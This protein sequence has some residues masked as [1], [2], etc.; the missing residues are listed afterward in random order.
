MDET[1]AHEVFLGL[2]TNLGD[3][4]ENLLSAL[5]LLGGMKG[6]EI[7]EVSS[8]YETEPWGVLD[9]PGFLNMVAVAHTSRDPRGVLDACREVEEEMGRIRD[10]KWGPRIIDVDILLYN[11]IQ[12]EQE[13][14]VIPH[15][16]MLEREFVLVP[17]LE[18]RPEISLPG[19]GRL[20]SCR[21]SHEDDKAIKAF[22]FGKE[23]WHG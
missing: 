19:A 6:M 4:R 9:Q 5:R 18:L 11:D 20:S 12:L 7:R 22:E 8:V 21:G 2:G 3:R 13:D 16:H 23:E 1:E 15:P 14:L 17:L 10:R